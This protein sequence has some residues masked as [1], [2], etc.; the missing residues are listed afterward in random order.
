MVG[1]DITA[2]TLRG[3][4][5]RIPSVMALVLALGLEIG[6]PALAFVLLNARDRRRDQA[7]AAVAAACPRSLRGSLAVD[8]RASVLSRRVVVTLN[9]SD[10]DVDDV[11]AAVRPIAGA[12]PPRVALVI[13]ARVDDMLP[14]TLGVAVAAPAAR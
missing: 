12:L 14:V 8:A 1:N 9:M 3:T 5:P 10:C 7:I 13:G 4:P 6:L 11:W 2:S